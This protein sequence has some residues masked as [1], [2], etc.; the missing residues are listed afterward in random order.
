MSTSARILLPLA[1]FAAGP[2][3]SQTAPIPVRLP[4]AAVGVPYEAQLADAVIAALP[5]GTTVVGILL[6]PPNV[7][8]SGFALA[9]AGK[10]SG[11]PTAAGS[12]NFFVT[13]R[14]TT[15]VNGANFASSFTLAVTLVVQTRI[16]GLSI[17]TAPLSLAVPQGA[18]AR[19]WVLPLS[20]TGSSIRAFAASARS[21]GGWLSVSPANGRVPAFGE[22]VITITANPARLAEGLYVGTVT[23]IATEPVVR[24]DIAVTLSVTDPAQTLTVSQNGMLFTVEQ[25]QAAPPLQTFQIRSTSRTAESFTVT[26]TAG[27]PPGAAPWLSATPAAGSVLS[28]TPARVAVRANPSGL[29]PGQYYGHLEV[30]AGRGNASR[31]VGVV[32]N[33][34][35]PNSPL[36][37]TLSTGGVLFVQ[38]PFLPAPAQTIT[39]NNVFGRALTAAMSTEFE[40]STQNWFTVTP[41][42]VTVVAG[43]SANITVSRSS[44][45]RLGAGVHRGAIAVRVGNIIRRVTVVA[46]VQP[47]AENLA[48]AERIRS[49][50]ACVPA[51]LEPSILTLT[52]GFSTLTGWPIALRTLVVDSCGDPLEDGTV[53]AT[54]TNGDPPLPMTSEGEGQ[55]SATWLPRAGAPSTVL[56]ILASSDAPPLS[57]S[58]QFGGSVEE[59]PNAGPLINDDGVQSAA[60]LVPGRRM[61]PGSFIAIRGKRIGSG[62]NVSN[63]P[64]PNT[65]GQVT[66]YLSGGLRIPLYFV[67]EELITGVVP[68]TL[69]VTSGKAFLILDRGGQRS[70][71][72]DVDITP[73]QPAIF[74]TNAS[75][76]GLGIFQRYRNGVG[77]VTVDR[78]SLVRAGDVISIYCAGLGSLTTSLVAGAVTPLPPPL[79]EARGPVTVTIAGRT[80]QP[81][82]AGMVP[83]LAG[84]SIV[85]AEVPA[86]TPRGD[87]EVVLTVGAESSPPVLLP[88]E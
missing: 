81:A 6:S 75:G 87:A 51:S 82:F 33:V 34:L 47:G 1:V 83:T 8:P 79:Y 67:S 70:K 72:V 64:Y 60:S 44:S 57:G 25:G 19:S 43:Q 54:F 23:V 26:A 27:G 45:V 37:P 32:L 61:A 49:A 42:S 73:T 17:S 18:L 46:I 36:S 69:P 40:G 16:A 31:F 66:A 77:P 50:D 58:R 14:I 86:G 24:F 28:G 63:P 20:N 2:G 52:Q 41:A 3:F 9:P 85:N 71:P 4:E 29:A 30:S 56:T 38:R 62:F 88:V 7:L 12:F 78:S 13:G 11:V 53:T 84:V 39:L 15:L 35:P 59:N 76:S 22:S 5:Q 80:V 68:Y 55:W 74:T 65:L 21:T 10:L 48:A